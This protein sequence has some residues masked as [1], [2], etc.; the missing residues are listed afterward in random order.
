MIAAV[1]TQYFPFGLK[2]GKSVFVHFAQTFP[3]PK[4]KRLIFPRLF[5]C[6]KGAVCISLSPSPLCSTV[7]LA[8]CV[9]LLSSTK[10]FQYFMTEHVCVHK[11]GC[12]FS[13]C[14]KPCL[15]KWYIFPPDWPFSPGSERGHLYGCP[16]YHSSHSLPPFPLPCQPP[17]DSQSCGRSRAAWQMVSINFEPLL[18]RQNVRPCTRGVINPGSPLPYLSWPSLQS[19][20][21]WKS[22]PYWPT[23]LTHSQRSQ[24]TPVINPISYMQT[25]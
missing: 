15:W 22:S 23:S 18:N 4:G 2:P 3:A 13:L 10:T 20:P 9:P 17:R 11:S 1:D 7:E 8:V 12:P 16:P 21:R 19:H 25:L 5:P 24:Q 6:W 14:S